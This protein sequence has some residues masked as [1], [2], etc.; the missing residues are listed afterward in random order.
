MPEI[1]DPALLAQLN[2]TAAP[3]TSP[4]P[5]PSPGPWQL[6]QGVDPALQKEIALATK[7][8]STSKLAV[9]NQEREG[10]ANFN[11]GETPDAAVKRTLASRRGG[12]G[13]ITD[14]ALLAQLNAAPAVQDKSLLPETEFYRGV[15]DVAASIPSG[16]AR[17]AA[18]TGLS[19][20]DLANMSRA[21]PPSFGSPDAM[22]FL[23]KV[24]YQPQ[25]R[26]G[27]DASAMASAVPAA[28]SMNPF[29]I[30]ASAVGGLLGQELSTEIPTAKGMPP[31]SSMLTGNP[32]VDRVIGNTIVPAAGMAAVNLPSVIGAGLHMFNPTL[33]H[34]WTGAVR[35]IAESLL[36][37]SEQ[38]GATA[39]S[40][41]PR[42]LTNPDIPALLQPGTNQGL[43]NLMESRL[44]PLIRTLG[45][46]GLN[47][48]IQYQAAPQMGS[49]TGQ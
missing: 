14:P 34:L 33:G 42:N 23:D 15:K 17:G 44:G 16:L 7:Q 26:Y 18:A 19:L 43:R 48:E 13:E 4:P 6:G 49:I 1:T 22:S 11:L 28:L 45:T 30:G 10:Q 32:T 24:M 3:M 31:G 40:A 9:L 5:V 36:R 41:A 8:G 37:S 27:R 46:F 47:P 21:G 39:A 38:A 29:T 35:K 20:F 2:G 12:G 25:T